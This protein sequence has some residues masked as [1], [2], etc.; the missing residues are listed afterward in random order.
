MVAM[1]HA[2]RRIPPHLDL[3]TLRLRDTCLMQGKMSAISS[4]NT[5]TIIDPSKWTKVRFLDLSP[6]D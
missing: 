5:L 3:S 2:K 4:S 6:T 1:L